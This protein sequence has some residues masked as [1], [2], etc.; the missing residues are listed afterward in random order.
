MSEILIFIAKAAVSL[1]LLYSLYGICLRRESFHSL[2][3]AVLVTILIASVVLPFFHV[4]TPFPSLFSWINN[5]NPTEGTIEYGTVTAV[6]YQ[7]DASLAD[8]V[9]PTANPYTISLVEVL[10][11]IYIIGAAYFIFRYLLAIFRTVRTIR[12]SHKVSTENI[13]DTNIL[14]SSNLNN[15][16][17]WLNWVLLTPADVEKRSILTHEQAHIRLR[18]S[19]DKMLCETI[20][21]LLWFVP[22]GWMLREDLSDI[23]EY[24]ADRSVLNAGFDIEEYCKLLIHRATH[25]NITPVVNSFNE[26][27]TKQRMVRM[28]Q[29][30]SSRLS[31]FKVLYL[32][33][34]LAVA[35][36]AVAGEK[37]KESGYNLYVNTTT[38]KEQPLMVVDGKIVN[39]PAPDKQQ[40]T[41]QDYIESHNIKP[42]DIA[43]ITV[44]KGETGKAIWGAKGANGVIEITTK[45]TTEDD[46]PEHRI[47]IIAEE[48]AEFPGG[49]EA[50]AQ[51]INANAHYPKIAQEYGVQGKV[52]VEFIVEKDGTI[53][54]VKATKLETPTEDGNIVVTSYQ[55]PQSNNFSNEETSKAKEILMASAV[56][57]VRSMPDWKPARQRGHE[58]RMKVT[59][60]IVYRLQ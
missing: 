34:I 27:K 26:S 29:P 46:D 44:L 40:V 30:K 24:E 9:A 6:P 22:F 20:V 17:S 4:T 19:Y 7:E 10:F 41:I 42:S 52:H 38:T 39:F 55:S 1:T 53:T 35:V 36:V 43:H 15:S 3:R 45:N 2:N 60:P 23:H 51:Y 5:I 25:I 8:E 47:F 50:M 58:V 33:P 59:M 13:N 48:P 57:M 14:V 21:R 28:F 18:H 32:L 56:A 12:L 37:P 54:D 11:L 16:C 31:A 49:K